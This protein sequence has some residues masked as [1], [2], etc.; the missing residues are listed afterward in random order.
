MELVNGRV[1]LSGTTVLAGDL[2][3]RK[4]TGMGIGWGS[5]SNKKPVIVIG[6]GVEVRGRIVLEREVDLQIDPAARVGQI[7]GP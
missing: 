6:A 3:V 1:E 5:N 7:I 2:T 4:P